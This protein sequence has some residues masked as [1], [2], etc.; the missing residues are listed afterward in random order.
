MTPR[1]AAP[2]SAPAWQI[3]SL[4]LAYPDEDLDGHIQLARRVATGLPRTVAAPLR[5]FLDHA[6]ATA[7]AD[8]ATEYVTVFDHRKRCCPF[9][10]YY[11]H[12]DTRKRGVALLSMKQTY[13]AAGLRL[14]DDELP[15][16]LAVVLEFAATEPEAG[17]KLLLEHRAGLELLRLALHDATASWAHVLD[18]V[19]ATLPPLAG[20]EREAVA[21]LAA[22]GPPEE[23]VG[24]APF[25]PPSYMPDPVG[26]RR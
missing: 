16:H 2:M 19:S 15:D 7:T 17:R 11:V 26:G 22:E 10:T 25:A 5:R 3:H 9:L 1:T 21:R 23:Q 18:S 6:E 14:S 24:L 12:G 13:A 8:L 20:D 4:L